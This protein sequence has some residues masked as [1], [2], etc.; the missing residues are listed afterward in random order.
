[1]ET[2]QPNSD[3]PILIVNFTMTTGDSTSTDTSRDG[4][5]VVGG[6]DGF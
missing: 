2:Q 1:M 6:E 3:A 4:G 5:G